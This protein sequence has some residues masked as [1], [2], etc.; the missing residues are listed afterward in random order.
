MKNLLNAVL[1][2]I[3]LAVSPAASGSILRIH[4]DSSGIANK[5]SL[6]QPII[7]TAGVPDLADRQAVNCTINVEIRLSDGTTVTGEITI[8]DISWWDCAKVK[9]GNFLSKVF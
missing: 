1:V 9:V 2:V 5:E 8:V 7:L 3:C 4:G 6:T